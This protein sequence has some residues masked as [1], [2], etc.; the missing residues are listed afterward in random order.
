V[1][2]EPLPSNGHLFWIQNSDFGPNWFHI[3]Q[4]CPAWV[5]FLIVLIC[6]HLFSGLRKCIR[7]LH[8]ECHFRNCNFLFRLLL[9]I[10][11]CTDVSIQ[12]GHYDY[13][14]LQRDPGFDGLKVLLIRSVNQLTDSLVYVWPIA[15]EELEML[16]S[17][18]LPL[19]TVTC[20]VVR[21]TKMTGSSWMIGFISTL[22]TSSL[23]CI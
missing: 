20:R 12:M 18:S 22:V 6:P 17:I 21:A 7:H 2:T 16:T 9:L 19:H 23:N 5:L 13:F 3:S 10:H 11:S 8:H 1:F 14:C 4:F 15:L